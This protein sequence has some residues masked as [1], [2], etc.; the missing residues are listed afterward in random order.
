[1]IGMQAALERA[2]L[3]ADRAGDARLATHSGFWLGLCACIGP[4]HRVEALETC[5]RLLEAATT[6]IQETNARFWLGAV[7]ALGGELDGLEAMHAARR[8]HSELGLRAHAGGTTIPTGMIEQLNG[9]VEAAER[10]V[11]EG[12]AIL[13]EADEKAYRSTALHELADLLCELGRYDEAKET[14]AEGE[15]MSLPDDALNVWYAGLV[16]A[17]LAFAEGRAE[18]AEGGLRQALEALHQGESPL[19]RGNGYYTLAQ[20]LQAQGKMAGARE[21]AEQAVRTYEQKGAEPGIRKARAL[22]GELEPA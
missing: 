6:P 22:L 10:T 5:R 19:W 3:H 14:L 16:R 11:R 20:I 17:K 7:K 18:E 8:M 21:A 2:H 1:M 15:A 12:I 4:S 13:A 9:E